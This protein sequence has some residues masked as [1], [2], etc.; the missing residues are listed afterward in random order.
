MDAISD[1]AVFS[2]VVQSGSF[3]GAARNLGFTASGVSRKISRF[4]QR[5]GA[6]LFNRTTRTL[7]LT[8]AGDALYERCLDI[9]DSVEAAEA[10]VRDLS[11]APRGV[12]RVAASN[13][14]AVE[15]LVPFLDD[16]LPQ[17][18]ELSVTLVQ[19]DG[20]IDLLEERVD[21]ALR[22]E[23][24]THT[25]FIARKLIDDP[26]LICA[27]PDYVQRAGTPTTPAEL[28]QHRCLTI[29]ARGNTIDA[30]TFRSQSGEA[31]Y[32]KVTS[33]LSGIGLAMKT[34]ALQG[35]GVARL[36]HFLVCADIHAGRL[37]PL[38]NDYWYPDKR[39]IYFVYP[40]RQYLPSKVRVFIDQL[41]AHVNSSLILPALIKTN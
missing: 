16:F 22:F 25:S 24:P 17:Y 40:N 7:A 18:P 31:E 20:D 33:A 38:L 28:A 6:R 3:V 8:E 10:I 15:V 32:V 11:A 30:W 1:M 36:A 5:L 35:L 12:L 27:A 23:P 4:E 2:E 26:W 41:Y 13:A 37:V 39:A 29:H 9:L 19:G 14:F 21:V 34:A